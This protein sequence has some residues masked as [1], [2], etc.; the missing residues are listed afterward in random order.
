MDITKKHLRQIIQSII[1][2]SDD[3]TQQKSKEVHSK[4]IEIMGFLEEHKLLVPTMQDG[5]SSIGDFK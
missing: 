2:G 3:I 5:E 1:L 4:S